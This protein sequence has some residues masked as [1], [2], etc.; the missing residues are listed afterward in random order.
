MYC[1]YTYI[2]VL[3]INDL[4]RVATAAEAAAA[5]QQQQRF[6]IKI[7]NSFVG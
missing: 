5:A 4:I 3:N 6:C 1:L 2:Q 7:Q